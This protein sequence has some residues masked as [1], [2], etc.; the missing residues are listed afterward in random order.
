MGSTG[1]VVH[2]DPGGGQR[3][4]GPG[5]AAGAFPEHG[6][7]PVAYSA[8]PAASGTSAEPWRRRARR[9]SGKEHRQRRHEGCVRPGTVVRGHVAASFPSAHVRGRVMRSANRRPSGQASAFGGRGL[10]AAAIISARLAVTCPVPD[11][12]IGDGLGRRWPVA[13]SPLAARRRHRAGPG[14]GGPRPP[15]HRRRRCSSS[16]RCRIR[17]R[18][19]RDLPRRLASGTGGLSRR[20]GTASAMST[21][22]MMIRPG[23][24]RSSGSPG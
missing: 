15:G 2:I 6:R 18:Q 16:H 8:A 14:P 1:C 7:P 11:R 5:S 3:R 23:G 22:V 10:G 9:E 4:R 24:M 21:A 20:R 19:A 12:R 13:G 17:G